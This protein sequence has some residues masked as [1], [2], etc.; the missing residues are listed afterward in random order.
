V[1]FDDAVRDRCPVVVVADDDPDVV[2]LLARVIRKL[3][4]DVLTALNGQQALELIHE[5]APSLAILDLAMP[6]MTGQD[7]IH[8][9]REDGN[10][11]PIIV[12]SAHTNAID[13]AAEATARADVYLT[14]PFVSSRL[15]AEIEALLPES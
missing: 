5:Y 2:N 8:S 10:R 1:S 7:V 13:E 12:L 4:Y 11:L 14:K 6:R 15:R 9:V 3:G